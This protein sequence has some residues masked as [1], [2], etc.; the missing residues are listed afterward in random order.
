MRHAKVTKSTLL[1]GKHRCVSLQYINFTVKLSKVN[2]KNYNPSCLRGRGKED[3][4]FE[5]GL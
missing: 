2:L 1:C 3:Y 4:K 5:A